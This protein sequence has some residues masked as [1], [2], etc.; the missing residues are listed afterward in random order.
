[1]SRHKKKK[2]QTN[3]LL[4]SLEET[5]RKDDELEKTMSSEDLVKEIN[6]A[7]EEIDMNSSENNLDV[8]KIVDDYMDETITSEELVRQIKESINA[9][10]PDSDD[11][12]SNDDSLA[13]ISEQIAEKESV[14]TSNKLQ[15]SGNVT[16]VENHIPNEGKYVSYEYRVGKMVVLLLLSFGLTLFFILKSFS[17][18][19]GDAISYNEKSNLDYQVYLKENNF[20]ETD[21]LGKDML[22]VANLI[23]HINVDFD[24][25]FNIDKMV[26]L[27]LTYDIVAK[28]QITDNSEK[29]LFFEKEYVLQEPVTEKVGNSSSHNIRKSI[30][31]DYN[32]YNALAN[33]FRT[34]YGLET[35]SNLFVYFRVRQ[36]NSKYDVKYPIQGNSEMLINIPLSE[37][38]I[39]VKLD[40][41]E[42]NE[43][44]KILA[45]EHLA[46]TNYFFALLAIICFVGMIYFTIKLVRLIR[47]VLVKKSNYDKYVSKVLKEYDRL[48]V[49]TE[50]APVINDNINV[51]K[52]DKFQELLDVRDNLKLPIKYYVVNKHQKCYF[53]IS[54][55]EELYLLTI[56]E[57]DL[58]EGNK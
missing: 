27:D 9:F 34:S 18:I 48:I 51:I 11:V 50:T 41:K 35:K 29:N 6:K 24:Y 49:E 55:E 7:L 8:D 12:V 23:D 57:V 4:N 46:V 17:T 22:Y 10:S 20:Y 1:M 3:E 38:A 32:Y 37:K 15:D 28:L 33:N 43:N 19:N 13:E 26:D 45:T 16:K 5:L 36:D 52:V 39:S 56:K 42:V 40:Y 53:F 31:I 21:H 58:E 44:K 47:Y 54:H 2:K 25:N 14:D 30:N